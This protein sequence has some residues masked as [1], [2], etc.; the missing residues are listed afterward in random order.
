MRLI[1]YCVR[2]QQLVR[3]KVSYILNASVGDTVY[4]L[5]VFEQAELNF[6]MGMLGCSVFCRALLPLLNARSE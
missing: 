6:V 3:T 2:C 5:G 1:K 4:L